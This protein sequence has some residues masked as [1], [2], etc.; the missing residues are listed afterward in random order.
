M[1]N[2][3]ICKTPTRY[4]TVDW[5]FMSLLSEIVEVLRV[6]NMSYWYGISGSVCYESNY[7]DTS[8]T[9]IIVIYITMFVRVNYM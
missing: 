3:E 6:T 4:P 5:D 1:A 8:S 2:F 9:N 7:D